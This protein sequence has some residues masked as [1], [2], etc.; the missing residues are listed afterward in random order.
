MLV[1][2]RAGGGSSAPRV[3][4]VYA[5]VIG[6]ERIVAPLLWQP[7][8]RLPLTRVSVGAPWTTRPVEGTTLLSFYPTPAGLSL[9]GSD[10]TTCI[11][12]RRTSRRTI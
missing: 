1:A 11:K 5:C 2:A 4:L 10:T 3:T 9:T 7:K 12:H 6:R 8:S